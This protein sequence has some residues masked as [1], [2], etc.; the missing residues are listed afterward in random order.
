MENNRI[1]V[2]S[3]VFDFQTELNGLMA[4]PLLEE[5]ELFQLYA[6][7][8]KRT[9]RLFDLKKNLF[10]SQKIKQDKEDHQESERDEILTKL[11]MLERYASRVFSFVPSPKKHPI[12]YGYPIDI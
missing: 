9:T 10:P 6:L 12:S 8:N 2:V 7:L 11:D 1:L 3:Q 5:T 4:P